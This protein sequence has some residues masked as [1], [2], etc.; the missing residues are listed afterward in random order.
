[1]EV[2]VRQGINQGRLDAIAAKRSRGHAGKPAGIRARFV[3]IVRPWLRFLGWWHEQPRPAIP[4][5]AELE[6]YCKWMDQERGFT[7]NTVYQLRGI[8]TRFLI[9]HLLSILYLL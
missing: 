6:Q 8:A 3:N 5:R 4:F 1:L 2:E 9:W 7:E